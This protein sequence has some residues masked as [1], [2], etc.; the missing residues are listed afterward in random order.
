MHYLR[1][2]FVINSVKICDLKFVAI[3]FPVM[4]MDERKKE[5]QLCSCNM[6]FILPLRI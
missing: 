5:S 2:T 1:Q 6:L 3:S 4:K